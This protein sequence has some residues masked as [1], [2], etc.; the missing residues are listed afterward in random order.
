MKTILL[1]D[2]DE[3]LFK[4]CSAVERE[5]HWDDQNHVLY[6][7]RNEAWDNF[8]RMVGQLQTDFGSGPGD[9]VLCFGGAQPYFRHD[10]YPDYKGG[11]PG[12]KPLCYAELR[13]RCARD[14][15]V[16]GYD[17]IEADDVMGI[18]A[19]RPGHGEERRIVC[20]QDKDL[21][22]V[23]GYLWRKG[24]LEYITPKRAE[25][26]H[27][28]QTLVGDHTDN[29]PGCP[30]LGEKRALAWLSGNTSNSGGE[31]TWDRVVAAFEK[32][33]L[34]E[35]DALL[36]ARLSRILQWTDWD[37]TAKQPILWKPNSSR[38]AST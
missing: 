30:G 6:A 38:P 19:T 7:N 20:T 35:K 9:T 27:L 29:Y 16:R 26:E 15:V 14:Y 17:G 31:W 18:L 10:L 1:I 2:G 3:Y 34:T 32:A 12:R 28:L 24:Q 11:R 36:Q 4:A 5:I 33:G 22:T 37:E 21:L 8:R 25:E 23:P 13:D